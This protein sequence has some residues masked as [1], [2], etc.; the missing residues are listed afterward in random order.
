M[1]YDIK[2]E[3]SSKRKVMKAD[4]IIIFWSSTNADLIINEDKLLSD[5]IN[6]I[7]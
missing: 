1:H 5:K 4:M 6:I 3:G 7:Y 2:R